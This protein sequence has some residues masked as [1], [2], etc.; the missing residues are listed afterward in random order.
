MES[1]ITFREKFKYKAYQRVIREQRALQDT[2]KI[3]EGLDLSLK[4]AVVKPI[5]YNLARK[6]IL[7]YEW[8]GTMSSTNHH[9]GIF[10]ENMCGGVICFALGG[11]GANLNASKEFGISQ[12]ELA[13]LAR[14]ACTYWTPVGSAS[15]LISI[16]L[17]LLAKET[18]AK[19][20]LAY[21]DTDAG[22]IGTVYQATNW[23]C[24]G[25]G[26][27]TT[28]FIAPNGRIYDQKIVYNL[29]ATHGKLKTVS[30]TQQR[31]HLLKNGW[32]EQSSNPK[33]RYCYITATGEEKDRIYNRIKGKIIAYPK[34]EVRVS[35]DN[36]NTSAFQAENGGSIPTLTLQENV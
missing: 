35:S 13:Y 34:R 2:V 17:K 1:N 6:I 21:S 15:K 23:H 9:Y 10:F 36:G 30:W 18:G 11:G 16:G 25:K 22:E 7:E 28:Q 29:R 5:T 19:V 31:D 24:I 33:F 3:H 32:R 14:G 26:D 20:A 4:K 27:S 8:L 12:D